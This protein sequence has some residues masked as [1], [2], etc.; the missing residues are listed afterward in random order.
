MG[1]LDQFEELVGSNWAPDSH[2]N[3]LETDMV[4]RLLSTVWATRMRLVE[5]GFD[6]VSSYIGMVELKSG[7]KRKAGVAN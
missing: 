6:K 4:A 1:G 7:R 5:L 3:L 2:N